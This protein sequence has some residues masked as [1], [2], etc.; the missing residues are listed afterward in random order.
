MGSTESFRDLEAM[1]VIVLTR[2]NVKERHITYRFEYQD[3]TFV[4][5]ISFSEVD[6]ANFDLEKYLCM[7]AAHELQI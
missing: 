7:E 3:R 2:V 6:G 1:G 5:S 4:R